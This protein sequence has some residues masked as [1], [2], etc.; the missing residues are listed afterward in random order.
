MSSETS[1]NNSPR[2]WPAWD[3]DANA[4]GDGDGDG[5]GSGRRSRRNTTARNTIIMTSRTPPPSLREYGS[6]KELFYNLTLRELRSKYKR[7]VIGWG[8]SMINPV[9]NTVIYTVVF[10]ELLHIAAPRGV[11][12]GINNYALMLL[13]AMLPFNFF[14]A[15]VMESMGSIVGN[16]NLIQKTYFPRELLPAATVASKV[17]SH[18]IEMSLLLVAVVAFGNWRALPYLP[19][20]FL[21]MAIVTTFGLGL[22]LLFSIGNVFYRDI[23]HFS[24]IFFF[25]WM[26]LTPIAYP[27]YFVGGG[28]NGNPMTGS[29]ILPARIVHVFGHAISLGT[30][31]KFNPMTDAVLAFQAFLYN[32]ELP[33]SSHVVDFSTTPTPTD[34]HP[35]VTAMVVHANV[36]WGDI[37][38]LVVWA[39]AILAIGL[40]VFRKY[41]ARLP[42]EL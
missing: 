10:S 16:Q 23:Y 17:V 39:V 25:I 34:L 6:Y 41:E 15:S 29:T 20:V 11:P 33:S 22:A 13:A 36:S 24:G 28:L 26:F 30:L 21:M 7:S 31:F 2:N 32:G 19:F 27:F 4:N 8:W 12:S 3:G 37:G 9:A 1:E 42:E 38:Y 40:K 5:D 35:I 14:Q 18:L